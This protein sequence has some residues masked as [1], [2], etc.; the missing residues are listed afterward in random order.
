MEADLSRQLAHIASGDPEAFAAFYDSW[1]DRTVGLAMSATKRDESF[2]LDVAQEVMI[3]VIRKTPRIESEPELKAWLRR[4]V[5]T[6]C[7]DIIKSESRR[8]KRHEA[9]ATPGVSATSDSVDADRLA[10]LRQQ[11]A[12]LDSTSLFLLEARHRFGWTLQ[13]IADSLGLKTGAVDRKL[14]TITSD[15]RDRAKEAL[16][17]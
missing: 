16:D 15:L 14:R 12:S 9:R 11:I 5:L 3:K 7:Y 10:W 13:R 4:S 1:F 8:L 6:T 17:E 2:C